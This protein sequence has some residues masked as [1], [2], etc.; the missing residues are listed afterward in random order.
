MLPQ[1]QEVASDSSVVTKEEGLEGL[2]LEHRL[3]PDQPT[4]PSLPV[5]L[6]G[7]LSAGIAG[8][9]ASWEVRSKC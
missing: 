7:V 1:G 9:G 8:D 2:Q 3:S 4:R 5:C 6:P